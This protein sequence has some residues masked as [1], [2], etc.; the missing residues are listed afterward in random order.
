MA[1]MSDWE[2]LAVKA[3]T[4]VACRP[5]P[6]SR[7]PAYQLDIDFGGPA[8]VPSSAR[9]TERYRP[10]DLV[11]RQ[12]IAVTGLEPKRVGGYRSDV[13]V[14]GIETSEGVV[15]LAPG[16]PVPNGTPVT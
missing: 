10:A 16:R 13:L 14:L 9:L 11:G 3:G 7:H 12:V 5:H 4:V 15:L 2:A 8:T 1:G 6:A